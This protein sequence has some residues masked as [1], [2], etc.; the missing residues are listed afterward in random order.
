MKKYTQYEQLTPLEV[1]E[2]GERDGWPVK[3]LV[4]SDDKTQW[5]EQVLINGILFGKELS[6]FR[7]LGLYY[8]YCARPVERIE[9]EVGDTV[10]HEY[11]KGVI[12]SLSPTH[13]RVRD[14]D[15]YPDSYCILVSELKP[16]EPGYGYTEE[17]ELIK[18]P[19]GYEIVPEKQ[20]IATMFCKAFYCDEEWAHADRPF[21]FVVGLSPVIRAYARPI[22]PETQTVEEWFYSSLPLPVA[23]KA[24][25]NTTAHMLL[26]RYDSALEALEESFDDWGYAPEGDDTPEGD[27][28]WRKWHAWLY[29]DLEEMPPIEPDP[30]AE[31]HNPAGLTVSQVGEGWR[32]LCIDELAEREPTE[33]IQAWLV[34]IKNWS[35]LSKYTGSDTGLTYRTQQPEGYFMSVADSLEEYYGAKQ[36]PTITPE[37]IEE[38]LK[39]VRDCDGSVADKNEFWAWFFG[40]DHVIGHQQSKDFAAALNEQLCRKGGQK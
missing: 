34:A 25:H 17:G 5:T 14:A 11:L 12:E 32:L 28:Y 23:I 18:P 10:Q 20:P 9:F 29:G 38:V 2:L 24:I 33:K 26:K 19:E 31:G 1:A 40:Y 37:M 36:Q 8:K 13:A 35:G 7:A 4:V 16:W 3:G 6:K 27:D 22:Q 21:G 15:H 39:T 30:I